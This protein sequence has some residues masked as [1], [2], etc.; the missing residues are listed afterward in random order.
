MIF[1]SYMD[2]ILIKKI[3]LKIWKLR[4]E[5]EAIILERIK[6]SQN[7]VSLTDLIEEYDPLNKEEQVKNKGDVISII[8]RKPKFSEEKIIHGCTVL[9]EIDIDKMF[10]FCSQD[11]T[12]GQSIV[13]EFLVPKQFV[14]NAEIISCRNYNMKSRVMS[15]KK[16]SHRA[17]A[18]FTFLKKGE[19]TLLRQFIKSI[20]SP[21]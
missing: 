1:D 2:P 14:L 9:S 13:I 17:L 7:K 12:E 3:F 16:L 19:R 8:Q 5:V 11:L 10:F 20:E 4:D 15:K 21:P 6:K 18:K